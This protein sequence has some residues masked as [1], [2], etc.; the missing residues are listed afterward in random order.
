RPTGRPSRGE[1]EKGGDERRTEGEMIEEQKGEE[2]SFTSKGI[3][4]NEEGRFE[5]PIE[6]YSELHE[7]FERLCD[8]LEI[9]LVLSRV[10]LDHEFYVDI[11]C[12]PRSSRI[13]ES[14]KRSA[15]NAPARLLKA[16]L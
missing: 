12:C 9:R 15:R 6:E 13:L 10:F 14:Q 3:N 5:R 16:V 11:V 4:R 8:C 1:G 7:P 2:A